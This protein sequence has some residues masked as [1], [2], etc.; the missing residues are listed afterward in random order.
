MFIVV[1]RFIGPGLI[2]HSGKVTLGYSGRP[3]LA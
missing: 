1:G 3:S 2:V